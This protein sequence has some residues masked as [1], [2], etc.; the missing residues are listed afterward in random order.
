[1]LKHLDLLSPN[2]LQQLESLRTK[3]SA[4]QTKSKRNTKI[5]SLENAFN[6]I[7]TFEENGG[8]VSDKWKR[9]LVCGLCFFKD[10]L[11]L[12]IPQLSKVIFKGRSSINS[13]LK[14]MGYSAKSTLACEFEQLLNEIPILKDN[15][16]ECR[17]WSI[18][19]KTR[20]TPVDM[21]DQTPIVDIDFMDFD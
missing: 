1:M 15:I 16:I 4:P 8:Y 11:A 3:F 13:G 19:F 12:N 14:L 21:A 9:C 6:E 7:R 17:L 2:E 20:L 10:S 5:I 18:S